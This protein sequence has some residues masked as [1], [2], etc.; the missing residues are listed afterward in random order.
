MK[1]VIHFLLNLP[2]Y[3]DLLSITMG[4]V[5]LYVNPRVILS[6]H[7]SLSQISLLVTAYMLA[8]HCIVFLIHL[9][10]RLISSLVRAYVWVFH[11]FVFL[12]VCLPT[13]APACVAILVSSKAESCSHE[14]WYIFSPL[15]GTQDIF[16]TLTLISL[17]VHL[18]ILFVNPDSH[19]Y[20]G[21]IISHIVICTSVHFHSYVGF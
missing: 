7:L 18:I 1:L 17:S 2:H 14:T 8:F 6:S 3:I 21:L 15:I 4:F 11:V 16:M 19:L 20:F 10:F 12:P 13:G 9:P 5:I